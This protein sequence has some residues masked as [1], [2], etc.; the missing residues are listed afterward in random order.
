MQEYDL[1]QLS[2]SPEHPGRF[3]DLS[4]VS[5]DPIEQFS[6]CADADLTRGCSD[7]VEAGSDPIEEFSDCDDSRRGGEGIGLSSPSQQIAGCS[8]IGFYGVCLCGGA[9]FMMP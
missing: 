5:S 6:D 7:G 3:Q 4:G 2:V 8:C 1:H 9:R